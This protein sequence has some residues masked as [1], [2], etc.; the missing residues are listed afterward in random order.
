MVS[1]VSSGVVY[2]SS[3]ATGGSFMG[4]IVIVTVAMFEFSVPSFAW[5]VNVSVP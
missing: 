2:V 1:V 4:V 3:I 5:Y